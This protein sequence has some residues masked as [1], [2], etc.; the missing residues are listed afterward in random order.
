MAIYLNG[1]LWHSD[2]EKI[3]AIGGITTDAFLGNDVLGRVYDGMIDEVKLYNVALSAAEVTE[4][5]EQYE[6]YE[7]WTSRY[8]SFEDLDSDADQDGIS[9]LLEYTLNGNPLEAD[10]V[11]LPTLNAL[12]ENFVFVFT[13]RAES[14]S[15]T[16]QVFQYSSNL[17]DWYDLKI[18]GDRAAEVSVGDKIEDTEDVTVTVSKD[19]AVD[20]RLFGRL[21]VVIE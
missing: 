13:R 11:I 12:G 16:T 14:A 8:A 3:N 7:A 17:L 15:D 4:L 5:Y 6:G 20:G 21:Q 2:T 18:T 9:S 10:Q 1:A 19:I